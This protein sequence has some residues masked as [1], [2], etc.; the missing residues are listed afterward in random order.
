LQVF[1]QIIQQC[2]NIGNFWRVGFNR[3]RIKI[4]IRAFFY[5]PGNMNV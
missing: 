2:V 1:G 3:V 5:A 4:A